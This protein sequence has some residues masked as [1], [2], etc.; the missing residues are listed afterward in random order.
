MRRDI[1]CT[2]IVLY[3]Q[4]S[5]AVYFDSGSATRKDYT[6]IKGVLDDAIAGFADKEGPSK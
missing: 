2:L 3:P 6:D 4:H 5:H 1:Y